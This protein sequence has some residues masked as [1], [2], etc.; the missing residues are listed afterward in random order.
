[1]PD[2][3]VEVDDDEDVALLELGAGEALAVGVVAVLVV[4]GVVGASAAVWAWLDPLPV[5]VW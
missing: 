2:F 5:L 1:V 4:P 3:P